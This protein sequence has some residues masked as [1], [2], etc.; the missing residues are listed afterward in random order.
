MKV[1]VVGSGSMWNEHNSASYL[2]D[3]NIIVD[4]P[5]GMCKYLFRQNKDPRDYKNI[6]ITHF[7]GDHFFDI[8]FYMLLK[9]K[10]ENKNINVYCSRNGKRKIVNLI[11]LAF[12]NSFKD[13]LKETNYAFCFDDKFNIEDYKIERYLVNHGRMKPAYGYVIEKDNMKIGFTGDTGLCNNVYY[14]SSICDY[15]FCDCMFINGT[16][17]HMGINHI[18]ELSQK[19]PNC[20]FIVSHMENDTRELLK[21]KRIVNVIVP[22]DGDI[23]NI[24]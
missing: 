13:V 6:L 2:I 18:E 21:E 10:S 22:E 8:P 24:I 1:R 4:M 3:D 5:N 17:K 9:S 16:Q 11:K 7:H 20:K 23:I 14:M 12:P 15:L 19:Y